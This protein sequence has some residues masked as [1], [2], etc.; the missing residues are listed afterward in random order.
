MEERE[1]RGTLL[2][3]TEFTDATEASIEA[4]AAAAL[5]GDMAIVRGN[6]LDPSSLICTAGSAPERLGTMGGRLA[7][8]AGGG[9]I[10]AGL[11][12]LSMSI[13]VPSRCVTLAPVAP[14]SGLDPCRAGSVAGS[15]L[16]ALLV[17]EEELAW[18]LR[19]LG[20]TVVAASL[21]TSIAVVSESSRP[22]SLLRLHEL[23]PSCAACAVG[24]GLQASVVAGSTSASVVADAESVLLRLDENAA[25]IALS[26]V[27]RAGLTR[28]RGLASGAAVRVPSAAVSTIAPDSEMWRTEPML[29]NG[30]PDGEDVAFA[31][32]E[33][34]PP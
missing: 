12:S 19:A 7:L 26:L 21:L 10:A 5:S 4:T 23:G 14:L 22:V 6:E 29:G 3:M 16:D 11:A 24:S 34:W 9:G 17:E 13:S 32:D 25:S 33:G 15:G 20:W 2:F 31:N 18:S 30:S 28:L 8:V 27:R 1:A